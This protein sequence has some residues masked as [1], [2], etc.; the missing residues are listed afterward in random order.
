M[1]PLRQYAQAVYAS[2][3]EFAGSADEG[4]LAREF[5][6]FGMKMSVALLVEVFVTGHCHSLEGEISAIKGTFRLKGYL[7]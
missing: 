2:S 4:T 3:R 6:I 5:E 7:F 1:G